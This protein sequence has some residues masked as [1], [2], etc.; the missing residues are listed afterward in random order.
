M[1]REST[2]RSA[3]NVF[4]GELVDLMSFQPEQRGE[5]V[6]LH[7]KVVPGAKRD[8]IAGILGERLKIRISAPP[9][10]GKANAAVCAIIAKA[11]GVRARDV[12][13]ETGH[14]NPEKTLRLSGAD[15]ATVRR[16]LKIDS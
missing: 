11:V 16:A 4:T 15:A 8:Q 6:L 2:V 12:T 13:V 14:T 1:D 5:D 7:V 10:G 3:V 9:E